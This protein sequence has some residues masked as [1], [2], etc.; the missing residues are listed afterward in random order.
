MELVHGRLVVLI[1]RDKIEVVEVVT[2]SFLL[3]ITMS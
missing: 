2:I 3:G 1:N